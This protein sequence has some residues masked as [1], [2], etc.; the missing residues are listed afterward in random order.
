MEG[1]GGANEREG[2]EAGERGCGSDFLILINKTN[3]NMF[4]D[5]VKTLCV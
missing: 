1:A 3:I 4:N 5:V 2:G